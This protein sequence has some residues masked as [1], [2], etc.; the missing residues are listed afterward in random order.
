M[1]AATRLSARANPASW[2]YCR[3][4]AIR[5]RRTNLRLE[6]DYWRSL[7]DICKRED[8]TLQQLC[9]E[10]DRRR[11]AVKLTQALRCFVID[12]YRRAT[13]QLGNSGV[14]LTMVLDAIFWPRIP[15]C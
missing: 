2:Q 10:V 3:N 9:E 14:Q 11:G 7:Q 1:A 4:V 5:G 12:Y 6:S 15:G 13:P 8:L